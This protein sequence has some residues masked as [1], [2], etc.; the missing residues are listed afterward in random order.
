MSAIGASD[1]MVGDPG[2]DGLEWVIIRLTPGSLSDRGSV[3]GRSGGEWPSYR[4]RSPVCDAKVSTY[5][6]AS[7]PKCTFL[8]TSSRKVMFP[9]AIILAS[10]VLRRDRPG[11]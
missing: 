8:H 11:L 7:T 5:A 2:G 4:L 1:R 6:G 9:H 10:N 3:R